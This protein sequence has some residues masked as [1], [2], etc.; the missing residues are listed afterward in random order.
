M[1][2]S[3]SLSRLRAVAVLAGG[4]ALVVASLSA[5]PAHAW[6]STKASNGLVFTRSAD[7]TVA[8]SFREYYG[9]KPL[10]AGQN[11]GNYVYP[12]QY[13]S[14]TADGVVDNI[15]NSFEWPLADDDGWHLLIIYRSGVAEERHV[16]YREP[17]RVSV[18][19]SVPLSVSSM[20]PL[21]LDTS[22]SVDGTLP[23][24]V[25]S[26]G[27]LNYW[28]LTAAASVLLFVFG[29]LAYSKVRP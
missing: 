6:T 24:T 4:A 13:T 21:S 2:P 5:S 7:D 3:A 20:P 10:T 11:R 17:L 29:I 14:Q 28:G 26:V 1:P 8:V 18:A 25:E 23:V 15:T 12:S 27:A 9:D 19:D 22:V 16:I